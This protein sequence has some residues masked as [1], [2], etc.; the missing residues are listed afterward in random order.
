MNQKL[1]DEVRKDVLILRALG[2]SGF[3]LSYLCFS[4]P[5][6]SRGHI[7]RCLSLLAKEGTMY[8]R[9]RP[10]GGVASYEHWETDKR[11]R[12][13]LT[14]EDAIAKL[15]EDGIKWEHLKENELEERNKY[16]HKTLV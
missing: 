9:Q 2:W 14:Q 7:Q 12:I 3:G 4:F 13:R 15:K 11:F 5:D 10:E 8:E 1:L 16:L 6:E